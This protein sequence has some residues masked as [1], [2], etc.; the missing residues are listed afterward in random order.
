MNLGSNYLPLLHPSRK[1]FEIL[2]IEHFEN[3]KVHNS[4]KK[5]VKK[6]KMYSPAKAGVN[7][8]GVHS[9]DWI[10]D[11]ISNT[12]V[13]GS[14]LTFLKPLINDK[15]YDRKPVL[16]YDI[17]LEYTIIP[18]ETYQICNSKKVRAF[19]DVLAL[20]YLEDETITQLLKEF[21]ARFD[22][23]AVSIA[24]YKYFFFNIPY[25]LIFRKMIYEFMQ[26]LAN[27]DPEFEK[28][29]EYQLSLLSGETE[30][31]DALNKLGYEDKTN[32]YER[33]ML[34]KNLDK[35]T[36]EV[37]NLLNGGKSELFENLP[38]AIGALKQLTG[39]FIALK[40]V[41][42]RDPVITDTIIKVP[43]QSSEIFELSLGEQK[44]IYYGKKEGRLNSKEIANM[45]EMEK[46]E[47]ELKRA[48]TESGKSKEDES[49]D[50]PKSTD[51]KEENSKGKP[52]APKAVKY[53]KV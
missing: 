20:G 3:R 39:T 6:I 29:Y 34:K 10:R 47:M 4:Y 7:R 41:L 13:D 53:R 9:I 33:K 44:A 23:D 2:Y 12:F 14:F 48:E 50:S 51:P 26:D 30:V 22:L 1:Y 52:D 40:S 36:Q 18:K 38:D 16:P 35:T 42:K 32:L 49:K 28:S 19:V 8:N 5:D 45:R 17:D 37:D 46:R 27:I 21:D 25:N 31:E 11:V 24:K 15:R 43:L